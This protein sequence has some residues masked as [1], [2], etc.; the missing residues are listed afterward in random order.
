MSYVKTDTIKNIKNIKNN[1]D[2][3]EYNEIMIIHWGDF[4]ADELTA[5]ALLKTF[6]FGDEEQLILRAP[7][8]DDV[9]ELKKFIA[10]ENPEAE[11]FIMD[12]GRIYDPEQKLFDHHQFSAVEMPLSSAGMIW[13]WLKENG[14]VNKYTINELDE[15]IKK[16]DEN[17]IGIRPAE[18]GEYSWLIR[19]FNAKNTY[20]HYKQSFQFFKA[21]MFVNEILKN[22]KSR[23]EE[24]MKAEVQLAEL[25]PFKLNEGDEFEVL[26]I[27]DEMEEAKNMWQDVIYNLPQ[28]DNVDVIVRHKP[29][30]DEWSAQTVNAGPNTYAKRG[31]AINVVQPYPEDIVFVHKGKFFMVAK[32]R[33]ALLGYL[34]ANLK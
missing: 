30:T 2:F 15:M 17:D 32:T 22:V 28:F 26:E 4:H 33:D 20:D 31:R 34:I 18:A 6:Y 16:I 9:H 8:Q 21:L 19:Q 11:I 10:A 1:V 25:K 3:K 14:F 7:H 12:V 29:E 5:C 23:S 13:K 27:P 24:A